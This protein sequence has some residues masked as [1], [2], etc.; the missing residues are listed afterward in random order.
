VGRSGGISVEFKHQPKPLLTGCDQ[1]FHEI[2]GPDKPGKSPINLRRWK[3][4]PKHYKRSIVWLQVLPSSQAGLETTQQGHAH[5]QCV[6]AA[7][8]VPPCTVRKGKHKVKRKTLEDQVCYAV[9]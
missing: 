1:D 8:E 3:R 2:I 5:A 9:D 4:Q 6:V 7:V